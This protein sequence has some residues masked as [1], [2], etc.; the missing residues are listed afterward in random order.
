MV[1]DLRS[2]LPQLLAP[3]IAWAELIS[4]QVQREGEC[5]NAAG[6]AI[7]WNVGVKRPEL[8]RAMIV[9]RLPLPTEP[10]L[11]QAALQTGLLDSKMCGLTLDYSILFVRGHME[12]LLSHEC[13]HVYQYEEAG[14]IAAFL[15]VYLSQIIEFGYAD[16]PLEKDARNHEVPA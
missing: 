12:R 3:A 1:L 15:P 16:A 11:Q 4:Q 7:A 2:T 8:I 13:R 6:L 10:L 14:S 5:L 9:D